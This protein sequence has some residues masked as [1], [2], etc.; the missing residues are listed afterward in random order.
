MA[1]KDRLKIAGR[2]LTKGNI[3]NAIKSFTI[4]ASTYNRNSQGGLW[5]FENGN[6]VTHFAYENI[7]SS[8]KA[9]A[10]CPPITAIINKKA[11]AF[12]N[13]KVSIVNTQGKAKN[14]EATGD[15]A[16]SIKALMK[17][18]NPLQSWKQFDAQNY[19]YQQI[20]G[21]CVV[22]PIKPV[23]F[24][25]H[26]ATRLWNIPPWMLNIIE[27]PNV[28]LLSA[29]S[30]K[31]FIWAVQLIYG[32]IVVNLNLDD[33]YIFKDFS[34]SAASMVF[35]ESRLCSLEQPI[36]NVIGAYESRGVLIHRR[37]AV[38]ILSNAG[39]DQIGTISLDP[40]EKKALEDDFKK[41]GLLKKQSSVIIT[42][43]ALAWQ[44]MGYPTKDLM[45][46]EEIE[47]DIM[48]MCDSY[49]FPYRLLSSNNANS[50]GGNDAKVFSKEL[51]QNAIIPEAESMYE[52]WNDFFELDKYQLSIT[53]DFTHI[54]ALQEDQ[55][56][57]ALARWR[58][59]QALLIEFQNNLITLN[60]W[61]EA[62]NEAPIDGEL[63]T[64]YYYE[65]IAKGIKFGQGAGGATNPDTATTDNN[66][67]TTQN[68]NDGS[69]NNP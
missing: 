44:N 11:Q 61:R 59:N 56:N 19:I 42:N 2:E 37:G 14:K 66:N 8:L 45:L 16:T 12:I 69:N 15:I 26:K 34:P 4:G 67:S 20:S 52:Q 53:K 27:R 10:K 18:P 40:T 33:I 41:Y 58:R 21:Y 31:D 7:N 51:Y 25:N 62:N 6:P 46:F 64:L 55:L 60:Q 5:L 30:V 23:G 17:R 54:S 28:N 50:L 3:G 49:S 24:P 39:K 68:N 36:N 57:E 1:F 48:R 9:Y 63:G 32:G 47:D 29:N 22:L 65:L 13:G 43:A 35:P 38:G